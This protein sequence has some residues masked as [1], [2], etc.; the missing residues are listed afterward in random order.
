[1][2]PDQRKKRRSL[3]KNTKLLWAKRRPTKPKKEGRKDKDKK[4]VRVAFLWTSYFD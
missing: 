4:K 2:F 1:M 3:Q